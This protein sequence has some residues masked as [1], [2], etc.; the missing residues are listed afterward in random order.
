VCLGTW[1]RIDRGGFW[2][3]SRLQPSMQVLEMPHLDFLSPKKKSRG[4]ERMFK[5]QDA[6]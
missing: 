1:D 2:P 4:K 5:L 6:T 3:L